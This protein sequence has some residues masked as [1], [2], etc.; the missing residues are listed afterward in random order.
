MWPKHYS[1]GPFTWALPTI[2]LLMYTS[3]DEDPDQFTAATLV[4][5]MS[6]EAPGAEAVNLLRV[7]LQARGHDLADDADEISRLY[8]QL[9]EQPE[10]FEHGDLPS[11]WTPY[12]VPLI[13]WA[14]TWA[15]PSLEHHYL[16]TDA[17]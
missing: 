9:I 11:E 5:A 8:G 2:A 13:R 15:V 1:Y 6:G 17:V 12:Q 4:Q 7:G 16:S 10:L 3:Q 14:A